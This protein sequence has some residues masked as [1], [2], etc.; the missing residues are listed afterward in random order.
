M[1]TVNE[2]LTAIADAIRLYTG[3]AEALTLDA[4]VEG[5]HTGNQAT[6]DHYFSEGQLQGFE[7]GKASVQEVHHHTVPE[8]KTSGTYVF[9]ENNDFIK[10]HFA[11]PGFCVQII[12][13]SPY[14]VGNGMSYSYRGNIPIC[15]NSNGEETKDHFMLNVRDDGAFRARVDAN[16]PYFAESGNLEMSTSS[17]NGILKAGDYLIILSV[18]EV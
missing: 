4:M 16:V 9:L 6:K 14:T 7:E 2:K 15:S 1:S 5:I 3:G 13:L 17:S 12:Y 8:T 10:E 11:D 18:T